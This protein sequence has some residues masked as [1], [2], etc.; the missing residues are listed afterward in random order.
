MDVTRL[1]RNSPV[2]GP[3]VNQDKDQSQGLVST[4]ETLVRS[5]YLSGPQFY[6]C[7]VGLIFGTVSWGPTLR[8]WVTLVRSNPSDGCCLA[9]AFSITPEACKHRCLTIVYLG[10]L[11]PN[12]GQCDSERQKQNQGRTSGS[13]SS[14]FDSCHPHILR[15]LDH[16]GGEARDPALSQAQ[17]F[18]ESGFLVMRSHA[19]A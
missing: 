3:K 12:A 9:L 11:R 5:L 19:Y 16:R 2:Q 10:K 8:V 7:K 4:S 18:G 6:I 15:P 17:P 14:C 1:G 13:G